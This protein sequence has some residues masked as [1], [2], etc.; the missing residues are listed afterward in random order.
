MYLFPIWTGAGDDRV[1]TFR[2]WLT[3]LASRFL[4]DVR[5]AF[6]VQAN[7]RQEIVRLE[8]AFQ[9]TVS[10]LREDSV[11]YKQI[12][13]DLM[14][15]QRFQQA[16]ELFEA[17]LM[18]GGGPGHAISKEQ[19]TTTVVKMKERLWELE[20][21]LEDRGWKRQL[22]I[23]ATEFSRYGLQQIILIARLYFV[24]N[25]LVKQGVRT[26][27]QY[28]FGRGIELRADDKDANEI[29]QDF[30]DANKKELGHIGLVEK[31]EGLHTD[32]N[33]FFAFIANPS[34][35]G[36]QVRSIDATEI[37]EVVCNPDD[38]GEPWY[39]RRTWAKQDFSQ[40]AGLII[41]QPQKQKWYPALNYEPDAKPASF[42]QDNIEVDWD[43][44][45]LHMKIGGFPKWHF[46]VPD[47]Y[48]AIDWA[49]AY[50]NFLSHWSTITETLARFAWNVETQGGTQA[51]AAFNQALST[52][53]AVGGTNIER[54]P[55]PVTGAAFVSGPGNKLTPIKTAGATTE[56]E[57]GR[58]IM[59]MVAAAFGLPE[60]F[61]G[62]ASTGS[63]ATA[64]SL[65]RPTELKFLERQ[66]HWRETLQTICYYVIATSVGAPK[67]KLREAWRLR[68]AESA[69]NGNGTVAVHKKVT[70]SIQ[71]PSVLEHDIA[72]MVSAIVQGVTLG[73]FD[74][75]A[76]DIKTAA[77]LIFRELGVEDPDKLLEAL[78]PETQY[79]SQ[80]PNMND[81]DDP[82]NPQPAPGAGDDAPAPG[83]PQPGAHLVTPSF[84]KESAREAQLLYAVTE[85]RRVSERL[86]KERTR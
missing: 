85:L 67:G 13:T 34:D 25:P 73:G 56:P 23:A 8:K 62:D 77:G 68:H 48:A 84:G 30:L 52:T 60:T 31:E 19:A 4:P 18:W 50:A 63:L 3:R 45:V 35:G 5:G 44:P 2:G 11:G 53:L 75:T 79:K 83:K 15:S 28:V 7:H 10:I 54:N 20:L 80:M 81:P 82:L 41:S 40:D 76:C 74:P 64:Q 78:W 38:A 24:K 21:A 46:G 42:G 12:K 86:L 6:D 43:T 22:A 51:I 65:D 29:L 14:E 26:A 69:V 37:A 72:T 16:N 9:D 17:Q 47:V 27:S 66:E 36:I 57:Q 32:G 71:F 39:Y 49:R 59:L 55:T 33:V 58:R 70:V 1:K 61:F